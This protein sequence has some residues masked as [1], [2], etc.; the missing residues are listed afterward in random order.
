MKD[1]LVS[2]SIETKLGGQGSRALCLRT[3]VLRSVSERK[4]MQSSYKCQTRFMAAAAASTVSRCILGKEP[5][6]AMPDGSVAGVLVGVAVALLLEASCAGTN[7]GPGLGHTCSRGSA[8]QNG[9]R[10]W[11]EGG[12]GRDAT[13]KGSVWTGCGPR[14][15]PAT[16]RRRIA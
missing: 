5:V 9:V 1:G 16:H 11:V 13:G 3:L 14:V 10:V 12:G 6:F 2:I 15:T 7:R 8:A 4:A